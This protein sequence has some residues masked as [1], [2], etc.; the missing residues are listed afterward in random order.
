MDYVRSRLEAGEQA[1]VVC[2]RIGG[3]GEADGAAV[4]EAVPRKRPAAPLM[5]AVD[6]YERLTSGPWSGLDVRL[7]HGSLPVTEKDATLAA[8]AAGRLHALVATTVVEVG[9]D[10]A[11]A[12]IMIIENAE[13]FGLSQLHQLRGRVGRGARDA[14]CVLVARTGRRS[15]AAERLQTLADT[16]DGFA[17]AEADLR[18]RGPGE[19][20]GTRQHGLPELRVGDLVHDFA[21]LEAARQDAFELIRR[22]PRL[23]QPAHHQL[24]QP[25]RERFG[26]RLALLDAG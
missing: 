9:V 3:N 13:R 22:D 2:P 5:S 18:F 8:F 1:F 11:N 10:V 16:T 17:I 14:L 12:T 6:L 20:L 19:L 7:L 4:D 26:R 25:L 15:K 24:W 23:E 21:L